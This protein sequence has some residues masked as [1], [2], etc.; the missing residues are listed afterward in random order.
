MTAEEHRQYEA[1]K[2][3][4]AAEQKKAQ[5]KEN[6]ETYKA[7][8][9]E[10]INAIFPDLQTVSGELKT[11]KSAVYDAFQKALSMKAEIYETPVEQRSNTFTNVKGDRRIT[12]GQYVT[13]NY[14]DTVNEGITKVKDFIGSLVKDKDSKMLV[15]AILKLLAKDQQGNLKASRV[16]Q[17]RKMA[18]ESGSETFID[19]VRI[20]EAAYRPAV[21]KF[22]VKAEYKNDIGAWVSVPLGMTEA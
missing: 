10:T 18:E 4:R 8:V 13:D 12:L 2:V 1:F 19:G 21:S 22:Y 6:R 14:D 7:L 9:D 16:M 11:K 5:D 3:N 17:L 20:I 15:T